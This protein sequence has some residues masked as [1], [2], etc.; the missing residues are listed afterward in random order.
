MSRYNDELR[1]I[2][3]NGIIEAYKFEIELKG[4]FVPP[5]ILENVPDMVIALIQDLW[6]KI[7]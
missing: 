2:Y 6:R 4:G 7:V 1:L 5:S 3:L